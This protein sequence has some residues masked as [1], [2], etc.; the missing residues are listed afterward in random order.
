[1]RRIQKVIVLLGD[2]YA[3]HL[4]HGRLAGGYPL[5][6]EG[7]RAVL[8]GYSIPGSR[9]TQG[10]RVSNDRNG[11]SNLKANVPSQ[12]AAVFEMRQHFQDRKR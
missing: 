4:K 9:K 6:S 7:L 10:I 1:M 11:K 3:W 8:I 5:V 2:D 12:Q